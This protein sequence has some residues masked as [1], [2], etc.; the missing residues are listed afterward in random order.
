MNVLA[1]NIY[2]QSWQRIGAQIIVEFGKPRAI[3]MIS[4]HWYTRGTAVCDAAQPETI[5]DFGAFPQALFDIQYPASGDPVLAQK[6]VELLAPFNAVPSKQWGLDHGA[7]SVL[8]K[9]FPDADIPVVQI[10]VNGLADGATHFGI[11]Q[12]LA[13][14][15]DD[16]VLILASGNI[17]HNLG[18]VIRRP[19]VPPFEWAERFHDMV[20]DAIVRDRPKVLIDYTMLGRDAE[21]SVPTPDHYWPLLYAIGARL[22]EDVISFDTDHLEFGSLSMLSVACGMDLHTDAHI[23]VAAEPL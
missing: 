16:G 8:V 20:K 13:Q 21:M 11:G 19:N 18:A 22:P 5:H 10:S 6:V 9:A 1:D 3:V 15:R 14:L 17:V 2:T 23:A 12:K 7:W 4:A